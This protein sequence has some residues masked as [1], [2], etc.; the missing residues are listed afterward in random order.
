VRGGCGV[1]TARREEDVSGGLRHRRGDR[2]GWTRT[3]SIPNGLTSARRASLSAST[4]YL[5]AW[6]AP[7]SGVVN[8]PPM[9]PIVTTRPCCCRRI[10]GSTA[11]QV[12]DSTTLVCKV[13]VT[14]RVGVLDGAQRP[15][16]GVVDQEVQAPVR[17]GDVLGDGAAAGRVGDVK[18]LDVSAGV[19][20]PLH[21]VHAPRGRDH[22][23]AL[24][25]QRP[26]AG[27]ARCPT[28][29]R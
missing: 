26:R 6:Y 3:T 4:A 25:E 16:A 9:D 20:K 8:S 13:R 29:R 22:V 11:G 2:P 27:A 23:E 24:G 21:R 1:R 14:C 12:G 15:V 18:P 17:L 5:L 10:I 7:P 28:T 19:R